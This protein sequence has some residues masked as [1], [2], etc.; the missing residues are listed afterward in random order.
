[1]PLISAIWSYLQAA[2]SMRIP[3]TPTH[4]RRWKRRVSI[5]SSKL[6]LHQHSVLDRLATLEIV[7]IKSALMSLPRRVR[8]PQLRESTK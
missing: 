7:Q 3:I 4:A 2:C 8:L 6:V 1:M 5:L